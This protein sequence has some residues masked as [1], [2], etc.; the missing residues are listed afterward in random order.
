MLKPLNGR[1]IVE[2]EKY[3]KTESGLVLT[4][5]IDKD[6]MTATVFAISKYCDKYGEIENECIKV[7]DKIL[8]PKFSGNKFEYDKKEYL[9]LDIESILAV[10]KGG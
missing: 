4:K 7:G 5:D 6:T 2:V 1:A 10:I 3:D 9:I 8:I